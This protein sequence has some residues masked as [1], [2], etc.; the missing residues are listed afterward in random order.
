[1][2]GHAKS[3]LTPE[4]VQTLRSE[5]QGPGAACP[6][7]MQAIPCEPRAATRIRNIHEMNPFTPG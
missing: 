1:V 5:N 4:P 2:N 7:R 6:D 3:C